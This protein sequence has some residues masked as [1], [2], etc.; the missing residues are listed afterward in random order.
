MP[1]SDATAQ[2][3]RL[4]IQDQFLEV[5]DREE[6]TRRFHAHLRLAP[7]GA[8]AVPL[9]SALDRV[10]ADDVFATVD[11]PA[12]DRANVDG[13]ALRAC[14]TFG[15]TETSPRYVVPNAEVLPPG[16]LPHGPVAPGT[17][18]TIATG[19]MIPRGADAVLMIEYSD[20][21]NCDTECKGPL[22]SPLAGE[23]LGK[24]RA[25]KGAAVACDT[26]RPRT[27]SPRRLCITRAVTP[28][29][30]ITFAGTD[31]ARGETVLRAGQLL[32]S[33]E[34]GVLAAIGMPTVS[35]WRKPRV[36]I[37]STGDEII[38]PGDPPRPGAV[39][40]SNG[41]ILSAAVRE[42]GGEPVSLGI[43]PDDENALQAMV[44]RGLEFDLLLLSGGTSKGTGDLSYRVVHRLN[45][46]GIVAHGIALKPGKPIC[47]AVSKG[48]AVVILPGF[49]TSAIFTFHEFVA[50]VICALAGHTASRREQVAATLP[51]RVN[52]ERGRT[53]F[54]LVSLVRSDVDGAANHG[55]GRQQPGSSA[56]SPPDSSATYHA[57]PMG[58]GSGSVTTYSAADGF[59]TIDQHIEL[60]EAGTP[61]VV[62]LLGQKL[63]PA[64][65]V[66]IGSHCVG[67]DFL[68]G[69]L[70]RN[71]LTVKTLSVGSTGGLNAARRGQCDL[72]GI[73]LMDPLTGEYN[74]PFLGDDLELIPGYRRMQG[75]VYR[76]GDAR[77]EGQA[78][79]VAVRV[80]L[81]DPHCAMINRNTGSGTRILIDQLLARH[82]AQ[83]S[84]V[85]GYAV[86]AKSHHT[87]AAAIAQGRADWGLAIDTV[88]AGYDLGFLPFKEE[89][90]DF[91]VPRLRRPRSAVR[92]FE[93]L[94][95]DRAIQD[96]LRKFGLCLGSDQA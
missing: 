9:A 48:K 31:I 94:L 33:R 29:E 24:G 27:G 62:Q 14:D 16:I 26:S 84:D 89:H 68:L 74:R 69:Q 96:R 75:L 79:E 17:A 56:A 37:L 73:H 91:V 65:L 77:F 42:L 64:D 2:P 93:A 72:A 78:L 41:A 7:L 60:L 53:E 54:L 92:A 39:Y 83:P 40:D 88:A 20:L 61:V 1:T 13:F 3:A 52:S 80:A 28:G 11:V 85:S 6:A 35:V 15:A 8:E 46:P 59:I 22:P 4:A 25:S 49:P 95:A 30:H 57:Y 90:Y 21:S 76:R 87:V 66:V 86:Q 47:L 36:A 19:G 67:L 63:T 51:L 5:I 81:R 50:P 23:G 10:L 12:F 70:Q 44:N 38:A 82:G 45:D 18:T 55:G 43:V 32:T 34:I 58:K 71:G